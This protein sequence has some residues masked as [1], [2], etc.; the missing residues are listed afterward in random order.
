MSGLEGR[1]L[2]K[3]KKQNM[4]AVKTILYRQAPLSRVEIAEQLELTPPT[5]TN[6]VSEL[7]QAGVVQELTASDLPNRGIGRKPLILI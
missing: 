6:I 3:V 2:A 5:I 7:I 4:A 1:N